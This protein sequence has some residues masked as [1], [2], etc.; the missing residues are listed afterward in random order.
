MMQ[1][2]N[3]C[4]SRD[5]NIL[6]I[7]VTMGYK[8]YMEKSK[9]AHQGSSHGLHAFYQVLNL[10]ATIRP[11]SINTLFPTLYK[12]TNRW[13]WA[14]VI[15]IPFWHLRSK[16]T[17][18]LYQR[19]NRVGSPGSSGSRCVRVIWVRPGLKIIRV[20]PGLDHVQCEIKGIH[21]VV[22]QECWRTFFVSHTHFCDRTLVSAT[23]WKPHPFLYA[24]VC[25]KSDHLQ[26][27]IVP[28]PSIDCCCRPRECYPWGLLLCK[29]RALDLCKTTP[30]FLKH[31]LVSVN[32]LE[33]HTALYTTNPLLCLLVIADICIATHPQCTNSIN[34]NVHLGFSYPGQI[35]VSS[36]DPVS[37]LGN[38]SHLTLTT[39]RHQDFP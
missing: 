15:N 37:T 7:A 2:T 4:N 12:A 20:W 8:K 30:T 16:E 22:V 36:C 10:L 35:R 18:G 28:R 13:G 29:A 27:C 3:S 32:L 17:T 39:G 25:T 9:I 6:N 33:S 26:I 31:V 21:D 38:I 34:S 19:W 14:V 23:A 5:R 1:K 11:T 24:Y